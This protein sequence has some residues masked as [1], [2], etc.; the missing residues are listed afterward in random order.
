[1]KDTVSPERVDESLKNV[2]AF[3]VQRFSLR[4][5]RASDADIDDSIRAGVVMEG[6][7]LWLLVLAMLIASIGLNV[8]STAVVIGA[9]LI[10]PLM[11]PIM[12]IGYGA[13]VLDFALIR[14]SLKNIAIAALFAVL[15]STAYFVLSPLRSAQSELLARTTPTIW[16][17]M[18]AFVGGLAGIIGV[19]RQEKSN[20]IPGVAIATALMPPLCTAGYGLAT[21]NWR[22]F[23]GAF[24]LFAINCVFIA[25]A[26]MVVTRAFRVERKHFVDERIERRVSGYMVLTVLMTLLPSLYLAYKLVSEEIF[27][28]RANQFVHQQLELSRTHVASVEV[29]ANKRRIEATL[30]GEVVPQSTLNEVAAR[31][32]QFG[33]A[34]ARLQVYQS[35]DQRV[36]VATLKSALL[37]DLYRESQHAL[38]EK[39]KEVQEL[40]QELN[41][42]KMRSGRFNGIA[43]ELHAL[44]PEVQNVMLG[45]GVDWTE[46]AGPGSDTAVVMNIRVNKRLATGDRE[47][48][49][50]WLTARLPTERVRVVVEQS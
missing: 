9:M 6:T 12:G 42:M 26:A 29:D 38:V 4:A 23:F 32:T 7:N 39:E 46:A 47:K 3:L 2:R 31:L 1:M 33:L 21:V 50:K 35:D 16:D 36:D 14:K 25:M 8:N 11:G 18:I 49:E 43:Q 5:D 15:A 17:V 28:T 10:S 13:G 27:K 30:I 19:T 45:E 41:T 37:G 34:G 40:Q 44:Y 22:Y 24:Y 20:V 48:I